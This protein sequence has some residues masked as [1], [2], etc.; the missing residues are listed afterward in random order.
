[1]P[2]SL[3]TSFIPLALLLVVLSG[4]CPGGSDEGECFGDDDCG[5]GLV[6]DRAAETCV[7]PPGD[8]NG[9]CLQRSICGVEGREECIKGSCGASFLQYYGNT[10]GAD[11]EQGWLDLM[12]CIGNLSCTDLERYGDEVDP[13]A[14]TAPFCQTELQKKN[15]DC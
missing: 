13:A 12:E 11:C 1:M 7:S 9:Y 8:C 15:A 6:C 2:K 3:S 10:F 4:G 5:S 14:G